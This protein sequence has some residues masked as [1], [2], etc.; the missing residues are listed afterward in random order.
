MKFVHYGTM[1]VDAWL[2]TS[3]DRRAGVTQQVELDVPWYEYFPFDLFA[4]LF[5]PVSHVDRHE[6]TLAIP[7]TSSPISAEAR[8]V[9]LRRR[10]EELRAETR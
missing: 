7:A 4:E 10:A 5:D 8:E 9:E 1:R 3:V 6:V 2:E